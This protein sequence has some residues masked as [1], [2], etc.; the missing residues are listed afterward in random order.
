[1]F[2]YHDYSKEEVTHMRK[3]LTIALCLL[4]LCPGAKAAQTGE[5]YV[6]LTFDGGP[7]GRYTRRLL[8]GLE[9]QDAK[10]TFLVCGYRLAQFPEL[11]RAMV[12]GG[13]EIGLQ[14]YGSTTLEGMSRRH[15]AQAL[16]DTRALLPEGTEVRFLR[17]PE[18]RCTD[19]VR[20]VAAVTNLAILGWSVDPS[21]WT[22]GSRGI[23]GTVSDGDV[24][25][26]RH[27]SDE[28]VDAAL[29][30]VDQLQKQGY[31]FVTVSELAQIRRVK[32]R[33]GESYASFPPE[34]TDTGSQKPGVP[35]AD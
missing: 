5:K 17:P 7:S 30:L 31:R 19:G 24:I 3:L 13:H 27:I 22:A 8:E 25:L 20:Q 32:V 23:V 28:T 10:V 18:D 33:P 11:A 34:D 26:I 29:S 14:S 12:D 15:I 4:L 2:I 21:R 6:A 1:M 16:A 35:L 9:K